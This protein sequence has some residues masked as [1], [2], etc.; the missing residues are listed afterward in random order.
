MTQLSI[1]FCDLCGEP[2]EIGSQ[3]HGAELM[4]D[5]FVKNMNTFREQFHIC[6]SCLE[7]TGLLNILKQML[8]Q[9]RHNESTKKKMGK[10][11]LL[12][13]TKKVLQ[14]QNLTSRFK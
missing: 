3:M 6:L 11:Y 2:Y 7:K 9:K 10:K 12:T 8:N 14:L 5:I 1:A 4:A 13:Q